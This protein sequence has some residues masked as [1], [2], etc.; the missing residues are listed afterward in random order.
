MGVTHETATPAQAAEAML[1][2]MKTDTAAGFA[3]VSA[4]VTASQNRALDIVAFMREAVGSAHA[5]SILRFEWLTGGGLKVDVDPDSALGRQVSRLLGTDV[6]RSLLST[7]FNSS[8]ALANCCGG[9]AGKDKNSVY[10]TA[11]DQIRWQNS[12]DC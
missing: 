3:Y 1:G 4:L 10:F 5:G 6:A 9:A 7:H 11:A 12:I 2:A 8:F